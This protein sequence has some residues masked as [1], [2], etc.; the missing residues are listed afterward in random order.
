MLIP[1]TKKRFQSGLKFKEIKGNLIKGKLVFPQI[2]RGALKSPNTYENKGVF[3]SMTKHT[4][5]I[6]LQGLNLQCTNPV[7]LPCFQL[8]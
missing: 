5:P 7:G 4:G 8:T 3:F 1:W 6:T 2:I